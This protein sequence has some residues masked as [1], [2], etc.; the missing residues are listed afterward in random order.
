MINHIYLGMTLRQNGVGLR[1]SLP[2]PAPIQ[3]WTNSSDERDYG[4]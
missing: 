3:D 1:V 2:C 4:G